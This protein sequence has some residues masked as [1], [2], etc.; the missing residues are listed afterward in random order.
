M[1][2][3]LGTTT[4]I[5]LNPVIILHSFNIYGPTLTISHF[6]FIICQQRWFS[7]RRAATHTHTRMH[8]FRKKKTR[9]AQ[10][11]IA[12]YAPCISLSL[13]RLGSTKISQSVAEGW[14][15]WQVSSSGKHFPFC[16]FISF[17]WTHH[18]EPDWEEP[19]Q[20][21]LGWK[22]NMVPTGLVQEQKFFYRLFS[23]SGS[24]GSS[25]ERTGA[26]PR[27][28]RRSQHYFLNVD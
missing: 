6:S 27:H 17:A 13:A 16:A 4:I 25:I 3:S 24:S 18:T 19:P 12:Y 9:G 11:I 5:N 10:L 15:W 26:P 22:K 28:C 21:P 23:L 1:R 8:G 7:L 2:A 20:T 14:V